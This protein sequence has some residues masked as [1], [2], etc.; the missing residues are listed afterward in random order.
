MSWSYKLNELLKIAKV[1]MMFET[2]RNRSFCQAFVSMQEEGRKED[3]IQILRS[4]RGKLIALKKYII[5]Q[6]NSL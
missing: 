1:N 3:E 6:L 2:V 5:D 4:A